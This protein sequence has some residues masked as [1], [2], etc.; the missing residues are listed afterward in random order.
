MADK[1]KKEYWYILVLT[2]DGPVFVTGTAGHNEAQWNK[3]EKPLELNESCAK[4]IATGLMCNFYSAYPVC[5]PI[6]LNCQP[7]FY[8][9]GKFEWVWNDK[10]EETT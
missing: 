10:K 5:A 4:N 3:D 2:N 7:Y 1:K 9:R 8:D 6:E